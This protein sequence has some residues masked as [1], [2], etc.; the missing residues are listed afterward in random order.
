MAR[1]L[2]SMLDGRLSNAGSFVSALLVPDF[3][4]LP[5]AAEIVGL[6]DRRLMKN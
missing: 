2:E 4:P 3:F 5:A 1:K 6:K